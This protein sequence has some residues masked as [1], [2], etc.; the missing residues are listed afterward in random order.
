MIQYISLLRGI[1]VSGK[2]MIKMPALSEMYVNLGFINVKTYIQS[3]NVV[4]RTTE[5]DILSI[6]KRISEEILKCF[7]LNIS[8]LVI[9][10][11]MLKKNYAENP[12][13]KQTNAAIDKLYL[14]FLSENP[15]E[16][17]L[18][19]INAELYIPDEFIVKEKV[20]YLHCPSSY[21]NT[22]LNN[23]FFEQ[24]L[25]LKATVRNLKTVKALV[26]L[27]ENA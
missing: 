8:V 6:E 14:L 17:M 1:N 11:S 26:D 20:I 23:T 25:K 18:D 4:F 22:R 15:S 27:T 3:G 21:G 9:E 12:Y 7:S 16:I 5:D 24:K 10:S 19:K 2:N 13:L